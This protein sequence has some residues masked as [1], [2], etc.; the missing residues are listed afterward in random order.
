[1][2][3]MTRKNTA[4]HDR[5][6]LAFAQLDQIADILSEQRHCEGQGGRHRAG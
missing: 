6:Q 4:A 5:Q 2:R 3:M 1:M